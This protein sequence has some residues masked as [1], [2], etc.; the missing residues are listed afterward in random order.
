LS[1]GDDHVANRIPKNTDGHRRPVRIG[2]YGICFDCLGEGAPQLPVAPGGKAKSY[3]ANRSA[4]ARSDHVA[5]L[6]AN[7][8]YP[9][10]DIPLLEVAVGADLLANALRSRGFVVDVVRDATRAG[11]T[12]AVDRLKA[13]ARP[14]SVVLV[15]FGGFG[16]QSRGQNY[17]IPADAKIWEERDVRRDG[18]SVE[19]TLSELSSS[20]A[21]K[22]IAIVDASRRNPYERRFREYSHGLA[23]IGED[24]NSIV[25]S[26]TSPE[27]VV[28]DA[29]TLPNRFVNGL[30]AKIS[31][32]SLPV[33]E[34]LARAAARSARARAFR[35]AGGI[36]REQLKFSASACG[37]S[38][39]A[40]PDDIREET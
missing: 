15:Y 27:Q 14:G 6:I 16:I 20:G 17:M 35:S 25:I 37:D 5:L 38:V 29:A 24:G 23:P 26:S 32:S 21:R 4:T 10:A 11:I 13:E 34:I 7:S 36:E 33:E 8:N 2:F 39:R 9:D 31:P 19:E 18:V 12:Q 22:R 1:Y 40:A 3:A 30:A 28:E